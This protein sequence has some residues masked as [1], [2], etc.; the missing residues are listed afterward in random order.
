MEEI[1]VGYAG[2]Y[3]D[4]LFAFVSDGNPKGFPYF[5]GRDERQMI[6]YRAR[7]RD[8]ASAAGPSNRRQAEENGAWPLPPMAAELMVDVETPDGD[9]FAID[10]PGLINSLRA[11]IE[12]HHEIKLLRAG[13]ALTDCA[14]VSVFSLETVRQL[15]KESGTTISKRQFRAN[16]YLDLPELAGFAEDKFVGRS[17]RVGSKVVVTITKRDG[18]CMMITLDP[19]TAEKSPAILKTV[20]QKHDGKA[21]VY[22]AVLAEGMVRKGDPVELLD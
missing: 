20:A 1:F 4:R 18:R 3:G 19:E 5:T 2:V 6:L 13:R 15:E 14:P 10:D 9:V 7:F 22:G 8:P 11:R 21:G 16:I 17:L 12:H